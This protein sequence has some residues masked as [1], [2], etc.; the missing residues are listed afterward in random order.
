MSTRREVDPV[1]HALS[2]AR[3]SQA[4]RIAELVGVPIGHVHGWRKGT[5]SLAPWVI[6]CIG[7]VLNLSDITLEQHREHRRRRHNQ[8]VETQRELEAA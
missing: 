7:D 8:D 4:E 2:R 5:T 3:Q 6:R 1:A